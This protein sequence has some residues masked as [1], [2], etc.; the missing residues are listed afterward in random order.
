MS[1][2]EHEDPGGGQ[3]SANRVQTEVLVPP[4]ALSSQPQVL[5]PPRPPCSQPQDA[6]VYKD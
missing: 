4:T 3:P 2:I 6:S 1:G 5:P